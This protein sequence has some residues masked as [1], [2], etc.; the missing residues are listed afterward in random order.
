[1]RQLT[2]LFFLIACVVT[3]PAA[4]KEFDLSAYSGQAGLTWLSEVSDRIERRRT[5]NTNEACGS[6]LACSKVI[7]ATLWQCEAES[8]TSSFVVRGTLNLYGTIYYYNGPFRSRRTAVDRTV[9][10]ADSA[11]S[12]EYVWHIIPAISA[13][14]PVLDSLEARRFA[15][16]ETCE[17]A[18]RQ[19]S[20]V[21]TARFQTLLA[22]TQQVEV[23]GGLGEEPVPVAE[24]KDV[25]QLCMKLNHH[26][27]PEPG[28]ALCDAMKLAHAHQ[29]RVF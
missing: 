28:P 21:I 26:L 27:R 22:A 23:N 7:A 11:V 12:H 8:L 3:S 5:P 17:T 20:R 15:T 9:I 2:V 24:E 16:R 10:D 4:A 19:T 13:V 29:T 1:M 18:A 6:P 25:P 14:N